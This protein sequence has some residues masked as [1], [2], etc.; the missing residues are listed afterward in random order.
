MS[1]PTSA[2]IGLAGVGYP[3]MVCS[4]LGLGDLQHHSYPRQISSVT[5]PI[6]A[7]SC[8]NRHTTFVTGTLRTMRWLPQTAPTLWLWCIAHMLDFFFF[9]LMR[10]G[11]RGLHVWRRSSAGA[12][13]RRARHSPVHPPLAREVNLGHLVR[14]MAHRGPHRDRRRLHL[15]LIPLL[16]SSTRC[17]LTTFCL[18]NCSSYDHHQGATSRSRI[19][20][21][22]SRRD[23]Q[24]PTTSRPDEKR[25]TVRG[26]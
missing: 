8:G 17:V 16:F 6:K 24:P 11:K 14:F 2:N 23:G 15:Y 10:S 9:F 25:E 19:R 22:R 21:R 5:Q 4:Q 13:R 1:T 7:V 18:I 3:R 12:F 26:H 20:S